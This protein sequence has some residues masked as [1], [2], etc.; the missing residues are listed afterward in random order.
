MKT[1]STNI[2]LG[3]DPILK[4]AAKGDLPGVKKVLSET[5]ALLNA[6]SD[7]HHRTLLWEAA[8][9]NRMD[10]VQYLVEQGADVNIPGRYRSE[11]LVLLTPYC[12]AIKRKRKQIAEYLLKNGTEIDIYSA[13]FLGELE[14]LKEQIQKN[15][16]SV[17]TRHP[18]DT[19]WHVIPLH[20]AIAGEQTEAAKYLTQMKTKVKP[21]SE[22]LLDMA[23]RLGRLDLIRLLVDAGADPSTAPVFSVVYKGDAEIMAFFFDKGVNANTKDK[24]TG[25]PPVA[26]VSRGDKGEHPEKVKALIKYGADVNATGPKGVT[27]LHAAAKAGFVNVIDAL[28]N[29]GA[30]INAKMKTGETPLRLA[31]KNKRDTATERLKKYGA[32]I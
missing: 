16:K 10:V 8:N 7:G 24:V 3:I 1:K 12:I 14:I 29:A 4:L 19:A 5:P 21:H 31:Q 20:Y 32:K 13:S 9:A 17:N 26:Y 18:N 2:V 11:T 27:A 28:L 23:C 30:N 25:W 6:M 22:L 15:K